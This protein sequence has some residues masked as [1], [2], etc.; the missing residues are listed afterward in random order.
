MRSPGRTTAAKKADR[1]AVSIDAVDDRRMRS[2]IATGRELGT[3]INAKSKDDGKWV[4]T[5]VLI[6]PN[7]FAIELATSMES[8]AMEL[9]TKKR[10]PSFPSLRSNL[11]W[12]YHVTQDL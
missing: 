10:D 7:R 1:G 4:K 8:A 5:I 9:V 6:L 12:K 2:T 11:S 3:G